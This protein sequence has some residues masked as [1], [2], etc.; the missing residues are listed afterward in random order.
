MLFKNICKFRYVLGLFSLENKNGDI[1]NN[2]ETLANLINEYYINIVESSSGIKPKSVMKDLLNSQ[3][4]ELAITNIIEKYKT[5][6][7][8]MAINDKA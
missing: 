5:H 2:D 6:P 7:S 8:I 3:N 1:V 4:D